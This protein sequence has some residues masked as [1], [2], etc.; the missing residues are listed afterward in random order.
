MMMKTDF[1][2]MF[3]HKKL[4]IPLVLILMG[5]I[6]HI[7]HLPDIT[8]PVTLTNQLHIQT[9]IEVQP[10][11]TDSGWGYTI[12]VRGKPYIHQKNIPALEGNQGFSTKEKAMKAGLLVA[13]K[14]SK[15]TFP[16]TLNRQ[17]LDSL[18][19]LN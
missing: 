3:I 19:L 11:L 6:V 17:E 2:G 4:I 9:H 7:Q 15:S 18:G 12:L 10:F 8:L 14:V 16:P 13:Y 5:A 1:A